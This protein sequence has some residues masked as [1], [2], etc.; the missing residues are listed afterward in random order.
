MQVIK[1]KVNNDPGQRIQSSPNSKSIVSDARAKMTNRASAPTSA[2]STARN[3]DLDV[4]MHSLSDDHRV[5]CASIL[6]YAL[7][8]CIGS[9]RCYHFRPDA[10]R[11]PTCQN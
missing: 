9:A 1:A 2:G 4:C 3:I 8:D 6:P 10:N 7:F 5:L 11:Y